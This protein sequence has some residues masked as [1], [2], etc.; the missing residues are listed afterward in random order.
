MKNKPIEELGF[1]S[2]LRLKV[3]GLNNEEILVMYI[4][5]LQD[6][7]NELVK[8]INKLKEKK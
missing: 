2:F 8:E 5:K 1:E 4:G 7:I 3:L 6:K